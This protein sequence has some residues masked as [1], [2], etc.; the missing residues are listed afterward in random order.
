[1]TP[2]SVAAFLL[3][4]AALAAAAA[5]AAP[6]PD[7]AE[8]RRMLSI[9][10]DAQR[11]GSGAVLGMIGPQGRRVYA[12]GSRALG[13]KHLM[14][15]DTV[16]DIGSL[17][18]V[19]TALLL[20]DAAQR[21]EL[22]L[23]DPLAKYLPPGTALPQRGRP[24][25]L[26]DLATQTSGLPLRPANLPSKNPANPYAGYT[27]DLL[28]RGLAGLKLEQNAGSAY[29]YSNL[30]YG[31]LS[32]VLASRERQPFAQLLRSRV[33][34][35]L[36]MKRTAY[37]LDAA[38]SANRAT[39]YDDLLQPEGSWDFGAL[40]GAGGLR[41]SANDLLNLLELYLG[42]RAGPLVD[43]S[44]L[45]IRTHRPGGM[46]PATFIAMGWNI[47]IDRGHQIVWKNGSVGGFRSFIGYDVH[48]R[49]GV[50]GLINART[51]E[52]LDDIGLYLLDSDLPV[53]LYSAINHKA[54]ALTPQQLD[55][56]VGSYYFYQDGSTVVVTRKD[57]TLFG[58]IAGQGRFE[59]VPS[60]DHEFFL[61]TQNVQLLFDPKG[62]AQSV[63]W[64]QEAQDSPGKRINPV[65]PLPAPAK[66]QPK[67]QAKPLPPSSP[68]H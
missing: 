51:G 68:Q 15:G 55:R 17:T 56:F 41:S 39:G 49:S 47:Y 28:L 23:D 2:K 57:K 4:A 34:Q 50:V 62:G 30:G 32:Y 18:K 16:F 58:E 13:D 8:L 43:A 65:P 40:E 5:Q 44:R 61:R 59:L 38:M 10:V 67:P 33:I 29:Q 12:Y 46:Q 60:S 9:R 37:N 21:R 66:P 3:L 52:G 53:N 27:S 63:I 19:C 14:D 20:A 35:P 54:V 22:A 1:M 42:R 26:A 6:F 25:T 24:I 45:T 64:R 36:G 7:D 31:L 48:S 11:Q